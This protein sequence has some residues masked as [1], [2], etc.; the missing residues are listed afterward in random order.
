MC[1]LVIVVRSNRMPMG[2]HACQLS[3]TESAISHLINFCIYMYH[4]ATVGL[5][6]FVVKLLNILTLV[7]VHCVNFNLS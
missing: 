7:I 6:V 4:R 1:I 3:R 2:Q 5:S